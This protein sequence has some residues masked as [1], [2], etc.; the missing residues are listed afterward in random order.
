MLAKL[1]ISGRF[2]FNINSLES[3]LNFANLTGASTAKPAVRHSKLCEKFAPQA[4]LE[5][6]S[7]D[8]L[9]HFQ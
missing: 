1:S 8:G 7:F 4:I 6:G 9:L 3:S 2:V 5:I